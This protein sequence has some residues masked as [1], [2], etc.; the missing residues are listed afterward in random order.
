MR[1]Q[2]D[3]WPGRKAE[4][5]LAARL[6]HQTPDINMGNLSAKDPVLLGPALAGDL[7]ALNA[8]VEKEE[9]A[10]GE[11]AAAIGDRKDKEQGN[12]ALICAAYAGHA[13]CVN[14]L[15]DLGVDWKATNMMGCTAIWVAS[16]Y[17]K[18]KALQVLLD[19]I[20]ELIGNADDLETL[21]PFRG[22]LGGDTPLIAAA[23]R[24]HADVIA[25][26]FKPRQKTLLHELVKFDSS[27]TGTNP[28]HA[29]A[30][31]GHHKAVQ[32]LAQGCSLKNMG[33]RMAVA[34]RCEVSLVTP[35][36]LAAERGFKETLEALLEVW[37]EW[38]K[39]SD[40]AK[41]KGLKIAGLV[42]SED[43]HKSFPLSPRDAGGKTP[44]MLAAACG[45]VG[46]VEAILGEAARDR[47]AVRDNCSSPIEKGELNAAIEVAEEERRTKGK[48][49]EA[50]F[51]AV[52]KALKSARRSLS[53]EGRD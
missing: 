51:E 24:G 16:G 29:A 48:G 46:C 34:T 30:A 20:D 4:L 5:K 40:E 14:R 36:H 33:Y 32:A 47:R 11:T 42:Q 8:E 10:S 1:R 9:K 25:E 37:E 7:N 45:H 6:L 35:L 26:L 39:A 17:G 43:V 22:N 12:T 23:S 41:Q 31:A 52:I 21:T 28:F 13:N 27:S 15:L 44:L 2:C 18:V 38:L 19:K 53:T 3:D 50:R 49:S